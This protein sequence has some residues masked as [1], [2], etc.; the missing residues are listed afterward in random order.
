MNCNEADSAFLFVGM[1]EKPIQN[2]FFKNI[3]VEKSNS[4]VAG[5]FAEKISFENVKVNDK[6]ELKISNKLT[7]AISVK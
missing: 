5:E 2:L 6:K 7:S 3:I 1:K 4:E